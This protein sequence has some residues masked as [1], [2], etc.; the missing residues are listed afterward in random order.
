VYT[1]IGDNRL[2]VIRRQIQMV[3]ISGCEN[4]AEAYGCLEEN[5]FL[6]EIFE[7]E[8]QVK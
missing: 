4:N 2:F 6:L 7:G 5:G 3:E 8:F 1:K